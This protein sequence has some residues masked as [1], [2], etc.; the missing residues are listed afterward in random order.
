MASPTAFRVH[1]TLIASCEHPDKGRLLIAR[2]KISA[3]SVI[4]LCLMSDVV[5]KY[6][7]AWED[8]LLA[9]DAQKNDA[10]EYLMHCCPVGDGRIC[11]QD[12]AHFTAF[13]NHSSTPNV[14]QIGERFVASHLLLVAATD[15][16]V[17]DELTVNYDSTVG[18]EKYGHE[19]HVKQFLK[20]CDEHGVQ[21]RP[22]ALTMGPVKVN[23]E[24]QVSATPHISGS[25][26]FLY[27][28]Q[29]E[30]SRR[31]YEHDLGLQVRRD[32]GSV[33]FYCLP[34]SASSLGVVKHG[35][36]AAKR[37][38]CSATQSGRDTVMVCLLSS[39]V[40]AWHR[41]L[42]ECGRIFDQDPQ[43]NEKFGIFNALLRD[44]DGYLI[45]IQQFLENEMQRQFCGKRT[46][47]E[48]FSAL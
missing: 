7:D 9:L 1:T 11:E 13:F 31:F 29:F 35:L 23:L 17:G 45:E 40:S 21:K 44:P 8:F 33:V 25:I 42:V 41:H 5:K 20:L 30:D 4:E 2:Q 32:L 43:R 3:K 48:A 28:E 15:I 12:I 19:E 18:Y 36:S 6:F 38:P 16:D 37:P 24:A 47:T 26:I 14:V 46:A 22:S 39:D 34:G 27:S 10:A